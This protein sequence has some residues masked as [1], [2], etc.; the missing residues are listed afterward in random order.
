MKGTKV[1]KIFNPFPK[2]ERNQQIGVNLLNYK[3]LTTRIKAEPCCLHSRRLEPTTNNILTTLTYTNIRKK[4]ADTIA[5]TVF[6]MM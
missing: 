4:T 3:Q 6:V 1:V 5:S 2:K